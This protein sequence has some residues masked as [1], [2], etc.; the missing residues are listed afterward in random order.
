MIEYFWIKPRDG[1]AKEIN[2]KKRETG[3]QLRKQ[4]GK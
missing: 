1:I 3:I 2:C 4:K